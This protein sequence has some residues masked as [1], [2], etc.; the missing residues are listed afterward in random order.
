M[1]GH[2]QGSGERAL[3]H[4]KICSFAFTWTMQN[5]LETP[6]PAADSSIWPEWEQLLSWMSKVGHYLIN[7]VW[8]SC[9]LAVFFFSSWH[10]VPCFYN[11][12]SVKNATYNTGKYDLSLSVIFWGIWPPSIISKR[13]TDSITFFFAYDCVLH[14]NIKLW[15]QKGVTMYLS[16]IL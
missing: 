13:E 14:A 11:N 15:Y 2:F 8:S 9:Q 7:W 6:S 16:F 3:T 4:A 12:C 5:W 1:A 10:T